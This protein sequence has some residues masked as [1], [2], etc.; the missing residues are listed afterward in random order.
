MPVSV[1]LTHQYP[2]IIQCFKR[3]ALQILLLL[4]SIPAN[5]AQ[6]RVVAVSDGDTITIE[7]VQGGDRAKVRLHGIDAPELRQPYGQSA[8]TF[9]VDVVYVPG[10]GILQELLLDAGLA[11]SGSPR[12]FPLYAC[13][14]H[15]LDAYS[16]G[17]TCSHSPMKTDTSWKTEK[18]FH[19]PA[20]FFLYS[21]AYG[22]L[23]C[24]APFKTRR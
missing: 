9:I 7:P 24:Y 8:K 11:Y 22:V 17:E 15:P 14:I 6:Y 21:P 1:Y 20:N 4:I 2:F 5:A 13:R 16:R 3:L 10:A 18:K 19:L 12:E 23:V